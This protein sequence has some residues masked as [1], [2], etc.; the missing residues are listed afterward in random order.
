MGETE[1]IELGDNLKTGSKCPECKKGN[2]LNFGNEWFCD[3]C[4]YF[5][6]AGS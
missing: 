2:E 5:N 3:Q 4:N 1:K 6:N